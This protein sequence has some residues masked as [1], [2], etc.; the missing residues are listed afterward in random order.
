MEIARLNGKFLSTGL[1][2]ASEKS[3]LLQLTSQHHIKYP[4]A[5]NK[6][7]SFRLQTKKVSNDEFVAVH[8]ATRACQSLVKF[9]NPTMTERLII[10]RNSRLYRFLSFAT[11]GVALLRCQT[12]VTKLTLSFDADEFFEF[13]SVK[14][15]NFSRRLNKSFQ[16]DEICVTWI[17]RRVSFHPRIFLQPKYAQ[18]ETKIK[19]EK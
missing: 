16:R 2:A 10:R 9:I 8:G 18:R 13:V 14:L 7:H 3:I 4:V 19:L 6:L 1:A 15:R 5:S 17:S 12:F 11:S